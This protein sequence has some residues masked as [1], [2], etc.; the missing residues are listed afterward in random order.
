M[1]ICYLALSEHQCTV[2]M[3]GCNF[4]C[5]GCFSPAKNNTGTNVPVQTIAE[6]IPPDRRIILAGGE[7][8]LQA[9]EMLELI[10][11]LQGRHV[12]LSTNG[13]LL[14]EELIKKLTNVE[15]HVDL[16]AYTS[17]LHKAY[18]GRDNQPVLEAI[19]NLQKHAINF[20]VDTVLIPDIV[21]SPEIEKIAQF[22]STLNPDI[23]L[24][25][26]RYVPV[27]RFSR[28]P[29]RDELEAALRLA[30]K[31]LKSVT[32]SAERRNHPREGRKIEFL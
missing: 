8:T 11:T 1:K 17:S 20:E 32:T 7:P 26:I 19:E 13:Y 10:D 23:P 15:V 2:Q 25:I 31:H 12:I 3:A 4:N 22:L 6:H 21:D 30:K 28:R 18:T 16:K 24:R 29:T 27:N 14:K 9:S 5:K